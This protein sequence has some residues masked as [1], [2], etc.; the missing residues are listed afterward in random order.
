MRGILRNIKI[1]QATGLELNG[2][3]LTAKRYF[4]RLFQSMRIELSDNWPDSIFY[5]VGDKVFIIEDSDRLYCKR[6]GFVD[7]IQKKLNCSLDE[8][9]ELIKGMLELF[10]GRKVGEFNTTN[11]SC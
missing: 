3:S 8:A 6:D 7:I 4:D 2:H 9:E 1:H 10:I 11:P 5:K